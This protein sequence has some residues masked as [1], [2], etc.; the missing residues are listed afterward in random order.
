MTYHVE[1]VMYNVRGLCLHLGR[2]V[3]CGVCGVCMKHGTCI[4]CVGACGM[5]GEGGVC[6]GVEAV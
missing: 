2:L 3:M 6:V 1:W 5:S 4:W